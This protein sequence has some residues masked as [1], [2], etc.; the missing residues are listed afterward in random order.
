VIVRAETDA[1]LH[2]LCDDLPLDFVR[3]PYALLDAPATLY[4]VSV[5]GL[6]D[7]AAMKLSAIARRGL[8]RDLYFDDAERDPVLPAGLDPGRW[9]SIKAFFLQEAPSLARG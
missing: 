4:G 6:R 1:A 2:L 7:L 8:R 5:A 3:Y 9:E